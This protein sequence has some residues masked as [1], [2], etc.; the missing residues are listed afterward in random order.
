MVVVRVEEEDLRYA[1]V[2]NQKPR[3]QVRVV[4]EEHARQVVGS[5][6]GTREVDFLPERLGSRILRGQHSD[7]EKI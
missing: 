7:L 4:V 5:L 2:G 6:G 3:L 1:F